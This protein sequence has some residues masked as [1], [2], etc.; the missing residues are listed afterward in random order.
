[1]E[2]DLGQQTEAKEARWA[3][4]PPELEAGSDGEDFRSQPDAAYRTCRNRHPASMPS[5]A[6]TAALDIALP[7]LLACACLCFLETW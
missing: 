3:E 1:M 4:R 2:R 7:A 5:R 6:V